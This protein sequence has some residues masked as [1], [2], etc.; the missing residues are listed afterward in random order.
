MLTR[1]TGLKVLKNQ[2]QVLVKKIFYIKRDDDGDDSAVSTGIEGNLS[3]ACCS[4]TADASC[5]IFSDSESITA[6]APNDVSLLWNVS[7]IIPPNI[8]AILLSSWS[9]PGINFARDDFIFFISPMVGI[10]VTTV[11]PKS[12]NVVNRNSIC[13]MAILAFPRTRRTLRT[14]ASSFDKTFAE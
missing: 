11:S 10:I 6:S 1:L 2:D 5:I 7:V 12:W 9:A 3:P 14:S 13:S 8:S 4:A